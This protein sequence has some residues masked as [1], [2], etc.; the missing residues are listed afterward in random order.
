M[1]ADSPQLRPSSEE[2]RGEGLLEGWKAI[3]DYLDKTE[4]TV[5][6]WEKSKALPVRRLAP[7][8]SEEQPRVFAYKSEIAA[9]WRDRETKIAEGKEDGDDSDAETEREPTPDRRRA[10]SEVIDKS[11][12]HR[13]LSYAVPILLALMLVTVGLRI[14]WPKLR[15]RFWPPPKVALAVLPFQNLTADARTQQL[16]SGLTDE[17]ISRL[18]HLH[19]DQ[20]LVVEVPPR[21]S[22]LSPLQIREKFS[23]DYILEGSARSD[24]QHG[25]ITARL[26]S[27]TE[28]PHLVWGNSYPF[29][30]SDQITTEIKVSGAI[31]AE[32]LNVLPH[33]THPLQEV[34]AQAYE[35]YLKGRY[36]WN[37]RTADSLNR[38][39]SY[40]QQAIQADPNYAPAYAGLADSYSLLGSAPYSALSPK[41]AFPKA[42][43][44]ARR[45]LK[46]DETLS[47]AHVSLGYS[48]LVYDWD[49]PGAEKEF[50]LAM[51]FRPSYATAH[52]FYAYY[53]TAV[54]RLDDAIAERKKATDLEP[55]S[56]LLSSALGEAYYQKRQFDLTI[57]QNRTS[58]DLDPS[59]AI[60]LI[61][62]GRAY[63]QKQMYQQALQAFQQILAAVPNDPVLL[64]L[65]GHTY[66][67][68]GRETDAR[69][70]VV[71]LIQMRNDRY[72]PSLYIALVYT[73]LGDKNL[74]FQW[75][76]KAY[77]ER[78]EYLVYL[79]TEPTADPLRDDARFPVFLK[80]L[81]LGALNKP[82][83]VA[84]Q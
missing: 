9:W 14:S 80:R 51:Q 34:N 50:L 18:G 65:I 77:E 2:R 64:A 72:V 69:G 17:M 10:D 4:R 15:E 47:E 81:G 16:A 13:M 30:W 53:L 40:F 76:D 49:F 31:V 54:G 38:S 43:A 20:L 59:Y 71:R 61:N 70:I 1:A 5:Q 63:E 37:R 42:E 52:E 32:V 25:E 74:A 44:A 29:D 8:P 45:A 3:A 84:S 62:L 12:R 26:I 79:P 57:A 36:L 56:P 75:L 7:G 83:H 46:L 66:A 73:G 23:A 39:I 41:E 28:K 48:R 82:I 21:D 60:A 11:P 58:L 33:D 24:D 68:S 22:G 6:R 67:V 55:A 19:P 35:A 27:G 78:C